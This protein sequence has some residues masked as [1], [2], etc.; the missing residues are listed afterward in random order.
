[1]EQDMKRLNTKK[2]WPGWLALFMS[3]W[4]SHYID[5]NHVSCKKNNQLTVKNVRSSTKLIILVSKPPE[6]KTSRNVTP[7]PWKLPSLGPPSPD[8]LRG[9]KYKLNPAVD[10]NSFHF[11]MNLCRYTCNSSW[12]HCKF[13]LKLFK[14]FIVVKCTCIFC[15]H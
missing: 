9:G 8:V 14:Q 3:R 7:P 6:K 5:N 15:W 11:L 10:G 2:Q 4:H 1:M 12:S 13:F